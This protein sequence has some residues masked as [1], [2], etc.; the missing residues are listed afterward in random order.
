MC[1]C[2]VHACDFIGGPL[3]PRCVLHT[4][5]GTTVTLAPSPSS[6]ISC[7]AFRQSVR[8]ARD[9]VKRAGALKRIVT[10]TDA[11]QMGLEPEL[12]GTECRVQVCVCVCVCVC[13]PVCAPVFVCV[14]VCFP[15]CLCACAHNCIA[16]P[17]MGISTSR[18]HDHLCVCVC[19]CC[20]CVHRRL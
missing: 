8:H 17:C 16:L 14:C 20:V 9:A 4:H 6:H 7:D 19:V 10:D 15:Q 3:C 11:R 2:A 18:T 5:A 1:R 12:G 13:G